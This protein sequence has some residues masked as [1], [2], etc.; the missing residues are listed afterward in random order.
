[1]SNPRSLQLRA[2]VPFAFVVGC[3]SPTEDAT[4]GAAEEPSAE[5]SAAATGAPDATSAGSVTATAAAPGLTSEG[6]SLPTPP[7]ASGASTSEGAGGAN[8]TVAVPASTVP[9]DLPPGDASNAGASGVTNEAVDAGSGD[10]QQTGMQTDEPQ[11]DDEQPATEQEPI[12]DGVVHRKFVGNITTG[13]SVDSDGLSFARY[14]DQITP[15]NA[16]KWG[17]VQTRAGSDFNWTTLDAIYDYAEANDLIFKEH[18]FVWGSQQPSGDIGESDVRNWMSA[19]CERYP[20]TGLIDV[21]NEPPPHTTP[22]YADAIGGGTNSSW[23]WIINSFVW[24]REACPESIL[25][26]N[27][28]NNI[29]W[30]K[31]H[32]DFLN[33]VKT[34]VAAGAPIDAIGAQAHDLDHPSVSFETV[35]GYIQALHDE[36]GLPVYITEYDISTTDDAAQLSMYREQVPYFLETEY[37]HGITLWGWIY[38]RT[39]SQAP[40]SGLV[41]NGSSRPSMSWLMTELGRPAP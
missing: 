39:W 34:I 16:G 20:D 41:R 30:P 13:N 12:A 15:E 6:V 32:G 27:D 7:A 3:S 19:F 1:M 28:Y 21:V 40:D 23:Q 36:T 14:W 29:E 22:A 5:P 18:T 33:I 35:K 8:G 26:L 25:L 10:E 24:A 11:P 37:V 9:D 4:E 38:G 2:L 31:D 17:S